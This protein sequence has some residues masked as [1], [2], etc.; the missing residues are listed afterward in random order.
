MVALASLRCMSFP[1][2]NVGALPADVLC[3]RLADRPSATTVPVFRNQPCKPRRTRPPPSMGKSPERSGG[4]GESP[5][6]WVNLGEVGIL[7]KTWGMR[8]K[9]HGTGLPGRHAEMGLVCA[10]SLA[11]QAARLPRR[12]EPITQREGSPP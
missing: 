5:H 9:P 4:V 6:N 10:V 1:S 11:L 12:A 3:H 7:G 2:C 8:G